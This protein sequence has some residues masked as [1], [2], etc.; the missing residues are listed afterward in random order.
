MLNYV[1]EG[2]A[3]GALTKEID[4]LVD[5]CN[6]DQEWVSRM[7][8]WEQDTRIQCRYAREEGIEE[9]LALGIEQGAA[10]AESR[11]AALAA[12]L[13]DEGRSDEVILAAGNREVRERLFEEF[14]L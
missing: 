10:Q 4:R 14:G 2:T 6:D 8:T 13:V 1:K 7:L 11:F 9:G 5:A 3:T 12:R